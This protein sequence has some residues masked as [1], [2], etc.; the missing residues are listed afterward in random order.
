[1]VKRTVFSK[2]NMIAATKL[3]Q[4]QT[5][6]EGPFQAAWYNEGFGK[7][8][9]S[10]QDRCITQMKSALGKVTHKKDVTWIL[11]NVYPQWP[12][13]PKSLGKFWTKG[14]GKTIVSAWDNMIGSF[15]DVVN[16]MVQPVE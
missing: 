13:A 11:M 7:Q 3:I 4:A 14:H 5:P 12:A 6:F 10:A 2:E 15:V 1:M 9:F 16:A 8:V